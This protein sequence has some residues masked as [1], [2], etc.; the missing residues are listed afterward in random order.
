M[1]KLKELWT[2][3]FTGEKVE[4]DGMSAGYR[5]IPLVKKYARRP[6]EFWLKYWQPIGA[7]FVVIGVIIAALTFWFQ[8]FRR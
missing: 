4:S 2:N 3:L 1:L 7:L 5:K 6:K 8:Y